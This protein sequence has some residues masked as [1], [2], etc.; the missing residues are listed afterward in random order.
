LACDNRLAV[1]SVRKVQDITALPKLLN[2]PRVMDFVPLKDEESGLELAGVSWQ[3]AG[4]GDLFLG[5]TI[6]FGVGVGNQGGA[7]GTMT[8]YAGGLIRTSL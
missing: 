5:V 7:V 3:E 6:L 8:D 4:T 1:V 2:I